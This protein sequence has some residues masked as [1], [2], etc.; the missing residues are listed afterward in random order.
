MD[1]SDRKEIIPAPN[2]SA[3]TLDPFNNTIYWANA[4]Q[5]YACSLDGHDKY[6]YCL[7]SILKYS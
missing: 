1:G 3:L 4:K 5:I 2:I 7:I 6:V